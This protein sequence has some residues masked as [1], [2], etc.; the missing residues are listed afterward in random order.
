MD[1]PIKFPS[2]TDVITEEVA[3]FQALSPEEKIHELEEA[4]HLFHFLVTNSPNPELVWREL[5]EEEERGRKAVLEFAARHGYL[6]A[7]E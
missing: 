4:F 6:P 2:Q 5:E 3:Q 7:K 1:I